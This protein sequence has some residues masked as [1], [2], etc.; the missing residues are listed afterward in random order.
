MAHR[1]ELANALYNG[2]RRQQKAIQFLFSITVDQVDVSSAPPSF[3]ATSRGGESRKVEADIILAADGIKSKTRVAILQRL[4]AKAEV[5][6][7][8]Q[9]SYRIMVRRELLE[10]D[11][12]LLKLI[13]ADHAIRWVGDKRMIIAYPVAN[14]TIFNISTTQ[15]DSNFAA[16]P[17]ATY[18]TKGSKSSMLSMYSGFCP[19]VRK[20][21]RLA[22][23][24]EICEWK[25]R[26]HQPLPTWYYGS[27][28]LVGDASHPSLPHVAQGAAQAIEDAAVLGVVLSRLPEPSAPSI[29][30]ALGVYERVRKNR[31]ETL[32]ELAAINGVAIHLGDG[33]AREERDKMLAK[34]NVR[35]GESPDKFV[36][37]NTQKMMYGHDCVEVAKEEINKALFQY[38]S[39]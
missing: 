13:D 9:A 23:E 2:C 5:I 20:L 17:S 34:L 21:L 38:A 33:A 16:A 15:P 30:K 39:S 25:L 4:G 1:S 7:T 37:E 35:K 10:H 19:R 26:V 11:N 24:G 3:V 32:V 36:D 18:T 6:D 27:T 14:K 29:N 12:E 31:A 22:P 8:G 28:A